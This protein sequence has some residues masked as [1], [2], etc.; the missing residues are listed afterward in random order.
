[1]TPVS[2]SRCF[3]LFLS[4]ILLLELQKTTA[5]DLRLTDYQIL[6]PP[7]WT[8]TQPN[9]DGVQVASGVGRS[10][11]A[12]QSWPQAWG[13]VTN[14]IWGAFIESDGRFVYPSFPIS[15]NCKNHHIISG[16]NSFLVVRDESKLGAK[17]PVWVANRITS[18]GLVVDPPIYL[19]GNSGHF[20][21]G[22]GNGTNFFLVFSN[23]DLNSPQ[24]SLVTLRNNDG[25]TSAV[26][27]TLPLVFFGESM[28]EIPSFHG[29]YI[30]PFKSPP[31]ISF[32]V[33]SPA[34]VL[35]KTYVLDTNSV[36]NLAIAIQPDEFMILWESTQQGESRLQA[37]R[38]R[39][40][41]EPIDPSP[42]QV[43]ITGFRRLFPAENGWRV[44]HVPLRDTEYMLSIS[45]QD[46]AWH[47]EDKP[48]PY[49]LQVPFQFGMDPEVYGN[50]DQ[51]TT[52]RFVI[53][54]YTLDG[55]IT[56]NALPVLS[57]QNIVSLAANSN[58]FLATWSDSKNSG[59]TSL[60]RIRAD[61]SRVDL[62][63]IILKDKGAV[64]A[65]GFK[66]KFLVYWETGTSLKQLEGSFISTEEN[67]ITLE[68]FP[69]TGTLGSSS[70]SFF[71]LNGNLYGVW[72]GPA[73]TNLRRILET[74]QT[75]SLGTLPSTNITTSGSELLLLSG[76][77]RTFRDRWS[78]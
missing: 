3:L 44:A 57:S 25:I 27:T 61:G 23:G 78:S 24:Y 73:S 72:Q 47:F 68:S 60:M 74:G 8:A 41:D 52:G 77:Q 30:L 51:N 5:G 46:G 65:A 45:F 49:S 16:G 39:D 12:W 9:I 2:P 1:M 34:G 22:G 29:K 55:N 69:L 54:S 56:T 75:E 37:Q 71:E 19:Q 17:Y 6:T 28:S 7:M 14:I 63:E 26:G 70:Y 53:K 35:Q 43:P 48:I 21:I 11:L 62:Q 20:M 10:L 13:E 36:W 66:D 38:F 42:L 33:F 59:A 32:A 15:R 58:A 64:R 18:N 31:G 67:P 40:F 4:V 50:V 76:G